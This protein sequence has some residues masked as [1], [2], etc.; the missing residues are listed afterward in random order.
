MGKITKKFGL[1]VLG[2]VVA[3]LASAIEDKKRQAEIAE[4]VRKV[5]AE[6]AAKKES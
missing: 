5:M 6:E 2:L 1:I 4:E 3:G